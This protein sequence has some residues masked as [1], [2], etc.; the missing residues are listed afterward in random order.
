MTGPGRDDR[1]A[2]PFHVVEQVLAAGLAQ[3]RTEHV[4]EQP[5]VAAHR[6]G[7]FLPVGVAGRSP[8]RPA[9]RRAGSRLSVSLLFVSGLTAPAYWSG[10][11]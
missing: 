5:H 2:E 10:R 8:R 4:A 3:H 1:L 7:Q 6:P 11:S 9:S